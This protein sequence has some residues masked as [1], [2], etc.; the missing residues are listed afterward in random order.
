MAGRFSRFLG[1]DASSRQ[2]ADGQAAIHALG[3]KNIELRVG[4]IEDVADEWGLFDYIIFSESIGHMAVRK[5]LEE[6]Y[7]VLKPGGRVIVTHHEAQSRARIYELW[8][9]HYK[10]LSS[11]TLLRT[12]LEAGFKLIDHRRKTLNVDHASVDSFHWIAAEKA[13]KAALFAAA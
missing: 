7:R 9:F 8:E 4:R 3:L 6:A 2:I 10:T 13:P 12:I 5:V 1:I 11:D